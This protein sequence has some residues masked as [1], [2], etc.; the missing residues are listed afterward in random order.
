M[1]AVMTSHEESNCCD[2]FR[3]KSPQILLFSERICTFAVPN[4]CDLV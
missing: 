1:A 2:F 4:S 3:K